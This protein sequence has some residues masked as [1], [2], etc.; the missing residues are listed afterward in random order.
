VS[1]NAA[2]IAIMVSQGM[3]AVGILAV[4]E[5]LEVKRDRTGA[6]RQARYRERNKVTRDVTRDPVSLKEDQNP[7]GTVLT[8]EASASSP[9]RQPL[10]EA[11]NC[12]N[13]NAEAVGW[14][15]IRSL[16]ANRSKL[17]SARLRQH[18][19]TGWQAA[20]V[21]ARASPYLA[22]PDPPSWFTF[23][24]LIK[25]ENF[26]KLTEGNYDRH[27][28]SDQRTNTLGRHQPAD[29]LSSTARAGLAVFGH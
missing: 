13:E 22:G 7:S 29:G 14:P 17:L 11:V 3:D 24:W 9:S 12:W 19:L 10:L 1:L 25:A 5:A 27:R 20:I 2:A 18:G 23:P 28:S 4:A 21:R 16:S 15:L 8:D 26:L 6:E